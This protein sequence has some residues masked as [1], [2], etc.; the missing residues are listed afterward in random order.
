[1]IYRLSLP[2]RIHHW[3]WTGRWLPTYIE[4]T[5]KEAAEMVRTTPAKRTTAKKINP[6]TFEPVVIA[7]STEPVEEVLLFSMVEDDGTRRDFSIPKK[8]KFSFSLRFMEMVADK[9]EQAAG[10]WMLRHLLGDDGF[11]ALRDSDDVTEEQF[12]RIVEIAT[13][14]VAGPA[15]GKAR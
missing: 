12:T 13:A 3:L 7:K 8:V 1:M 11:E 14:I 4:G 9:G 2:V 15:Q 5:T 10:V 6:D